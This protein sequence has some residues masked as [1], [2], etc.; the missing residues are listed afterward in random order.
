MRPCVTYEAVKRQL[1][2]L[3]HTVPDAAIR[4]YLADLQ[5]G[6]EDEPA[7]VRAASQMSG[8]SDHDTVREAFRHLNLI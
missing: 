3:G 6:S 7:S 2:L 1:E 4:A 5:K 8:R